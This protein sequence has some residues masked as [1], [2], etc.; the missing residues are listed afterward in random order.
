MTNPTIVLDIGQFST[1]AGFAGEDSP[2]LVFI[3]MVGK[4][5]YRNLDVQYGG[6]EQELYVGAEI[7]SLGLYKISY[8]IEKGVITDWEQFEKILEY[9]F[10][11][12]RVDPTLVNILF[13]IHPLFPQQDIERLFQLFLEQY[14]CMAF[15]PVLDSMMT[16]YSGGFQTGLVIEIGDSSTRIVPIYNGYKLEHAVKILDL[17]GRVL[18]RETER[19]L[20]SMGFSTESS[21][22]RDLA[23][24]LKERACF[25][26]LD[27][28]EDVNRA[29]Q[30]GKQFSLP[31]GSTLALTNERFRI[32]EILFDPTIINSEETP[33]PQAIMDVI[34]ECDMDI[35]PQLL[36]NIFL[37]GGSSM[38]PNFKSRI[39]KE[40][41]LEL[42]RRKK[43]DQVVKIIAPRERT[44]S[45]WVGGSILALIPE[46][47]NN[48]ITRA[49]Y[50]NEG[51]PPN[52]L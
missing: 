13:A 28:K 51:I 30:Y 48:W 33:L 6:H 52:L 44:Y 40:L 36:K 2:S 3:T 14:Q 34:G 8:P 37:S 12:L 39:Y 43:K 42:A 17:G 9:V 27:Y 24:V 38:F 35:R 16:L 29:E 1:K 21:V 47:S 7:E 4:P 31:D 50:F 11:N 10:Y 20:T 19:I 18:T 45:V 41:E 23:R 49:K 25:V 5:K 22:T 26:S 15:Y 46:F 32:P